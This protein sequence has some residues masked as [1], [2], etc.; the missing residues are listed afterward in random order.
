MIGDNNSSWLGDTSGWLDRRREDVRERR[1]RE[2]RE[3][4]ADEL[5][6]QRALDGDQARKLVLNDDGWRVL[7]NAI[8]L[9]WHTDNPRADNNQQRLIYSELYELRELLF[10]AGAL[11]Q[12]FES[13]DTLT[14]AEKRKQIRSLQGSDLPFAILRATDLDHQT[15]ER[16]PQAVYDALFSARDSE[17]RAPLSRLGKC[18]LTDSLRK[19]VLCYFRGEAQPINFQGV[20]QP[21]NNDEAGKTAP[22]GGPRSGADRSQEKVATKVFYEIYIKDPEARLTRDEADALLLPYFPVNNAR[23]RIWDAIDA[24]LWKTRGRPH[25]DLRRADKDLIAVKLRA[26][27]K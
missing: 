14:V 10:C 6:R 20:A 11:A 17:L 9:A 26:A 7:G 12:E 24:A 3:R 8:L 16:I 23:E 21:I 13:P 5:K 19:S 25:A 2:T 15:C 22:R 1:D 4:A 18:N 27:L